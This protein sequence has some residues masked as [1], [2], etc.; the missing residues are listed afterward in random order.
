MGEVGPVSTVLF[1]GSPPPVVPPVL[2]VLSGLTRR[3]G[4][5]RCPKVVRVPTSLFPSLT[6]TIP[7]SLNLHVTTPT[8]TYTHPP[9]TPIIPRPLPP[10][11]RRSEPRVFGLD[12]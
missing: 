8:Y 1:V 12:L 5:V 10:S 3:G 6:L 7:L 4:D 2:L 11:T 9:P